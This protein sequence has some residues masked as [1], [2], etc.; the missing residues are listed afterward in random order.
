M[1]ALVLLAIAFGAGLLGMTYSH[2][3]A[4]DASAV[5]D[6]IAGETV[7][8]SAAVTASGTFPQNALSGAGFVVFTNTTNTPGTLT[9]RTAAQLYADLIAQLGIIPANGYQ[10]MVQIIHA[11]SGTLTPAG[12]TGVTLSSLTT[13]ITT[14][15]T[16]T[17]RTFV[18]TL[19]NPTTVTMQSVGALAT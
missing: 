16:F 17:S 5:L 18:F 9:T 7:S 8:T 15:A 14:I 19:V 2:Q 10:W 13:G 11:G 1:H 6:I 12:G 4:L 3:G